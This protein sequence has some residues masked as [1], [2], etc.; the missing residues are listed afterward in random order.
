MRASDCQIP[1]EEGLDG[2]WQISTHRRDSDYQIPIEGWGSDWHIS[3]E[4][5]DSECQIP[6]DGMVT[7][8]SP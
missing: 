3:T 1:T 2:D 6:I 8:K 7:V 5:R 4:R